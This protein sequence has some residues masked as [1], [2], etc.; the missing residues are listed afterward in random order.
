MRD[1]FCYL[2]CPIGWHPLYMVI[3]FSYPCTD[4]RRLT[5]GILS[6]KCFVRQFLHRANDI[7]CTYTNLDSITY[8]TPKL[9]CNSLLFVGRKPVQRV[10]LLK[11]VGNC[12]TMVSITILYCN[13]IILW[14]HHRI[15]DSSL[16][17]TSL[18]DAYLYSSI[19]LLLCFRIDVSCIGPS[20][21]KPTL[22]SLSCVY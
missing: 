13:I 20:Y 4:M 9:I 22:S 14:D 7:E 11:K 21:D 5:T 12:N 8:Y 1:V 3:L 10:T 2:H 17:D 18:C 6:E 16:T 15:C 19:L